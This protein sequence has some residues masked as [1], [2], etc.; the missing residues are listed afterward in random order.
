M[1]ASGHGAKDC[2]LPLL[3]C[4]VAVSATSSNP[5]SE[6]DTESLAGLCGASD[7][8]LLHLQRVV[9]ASFVAQGTTGCEAGNETGRGDWP[10]QVVYMNN[11][12]VAL[13]NSTACL[14]TTQAKKTVAWLDVTSN[15]SSKSM[16]WWN[17]FV[18]QPQYYDMPRKSGARIESPATLGRKCWAFAYLAARWVPLRPALERI[19]TN[20]G[21]NAKAFVAAYDSAVP[22]SMDLCHRVMA[23]CF[24]NRTY[25]PSRNGT[26]PSAYEQFFVGFQWENNIYDRNGVIDYAFPAYA[27]T[28]SFRSA[29]AFAANAA[30]NYII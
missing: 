21:T 6:G 28:A 27:M 5:R 17:W 22:F 10:S 1:V 11:L 9:C 19:V 24:V 13:T 20:A 8:R 4:L 18:F 3:F 30:V 26:C 29:A 7:A 16:F 15:A 12:L 23:N 2:R 25:N 14:N